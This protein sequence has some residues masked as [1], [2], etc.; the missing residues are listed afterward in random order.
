MGLVAAR[1]CC[2]CRRL[3][4]DVDDMQALVH[5]QIHFRG[6]WGKASNYRTIPLCHHHHADP[7]EGV[8]GLNSEAFEAMYGFSEM[9]LI[10]E[11]QRA[12]I[13]HVPKNERVYQ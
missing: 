3:G 12:L 7:H 4:Y 10:D 11:T 2:V 8:H 6:G 13:V 1:G 5:H 9:D